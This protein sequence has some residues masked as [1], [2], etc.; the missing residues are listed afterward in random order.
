[1][2]GVPIT[3]VFYWIQ[4][5]DTTYVLGPAETRH[6]SLNVTLLVWGGRSQR[7]MLWPTPALRATFSTTVEGQMSYRPTCGNIRNRSTLIALIVLAVSPAFGQ[8]SARNNPTA[9]ETLHWMQTTLENG[10]GD[11]SVGHEVRS[12]RLADFDGCKVHFIHSTHQEAFLYGEPAPDKKP[13]HMDHF[14][15][16]SDIDP[17]ATTFTKGIP[18]KLPALL[19]I[20]TRNDEKKIRS[21]YAWQSEADSEPE[22]TYIIFSLDSIDT[23]YV[24][25]FARAF[26]HAVEACGGKPSTF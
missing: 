20:H 17:D 13:W 8:S 18:L 24:G 26:K 12:T 4:T 22:G 1:M 16:L 11:Y 23:E 15:E 6:Q 14:F 10:G 3:K 7:A 9:K 21:K 5:D 2:V 25:R 19:T